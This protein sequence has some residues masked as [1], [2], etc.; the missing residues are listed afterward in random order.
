MKIIERNIFI[1]MVFGLLAFSIAGCAQ[2]SELEAQIPEATPSITVYESESAAKGE[3]LPSETISVN[4]NEPSVSPFG[5]DYEIVITMDGDATGEYDLDYQ[6][7][8]ILY[9]TPFSEIVTLLGQPEKEEEAQ[10]QEYDGKWHQ[11]V[12]YMSKGISLQLR[13]MEEKGEYLTQ[14]VSVFSPF[15][16]KSAEGIGIGSSE[17]EVRATYNDMINP[18]ESSEKVIILGSVYWGVHFHFSDE[19]VVESIT[20]GADAE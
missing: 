17:N 10:Y 5:E 3:V 18:D 7:G 9:G 1:A 15:S 19:D 2:T 13:S 8:P 11:S 14:K 16:G 4:E 12:V 20:F 6:V